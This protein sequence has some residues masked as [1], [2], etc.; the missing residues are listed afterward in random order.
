MDFFSCQETD[1]Y[2][3]IVESDVV[4]GSSAIDSDNYHKE[5][6]ELQPQAST[7]LAILNN[8][9]SRLKSMEMNDPRVPT[10]RYVREY[11]MN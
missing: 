4:I 8:I 10:Y 6:Q 3:F 7:L 5:L 1:D 2:D 9:R 11:K